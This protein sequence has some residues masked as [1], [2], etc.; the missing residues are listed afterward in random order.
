MHLRC[1]APLHKQL[2][3]VLCHITFIALIK[4]NKKYQYCWL[5]DSSST[6]LCPV[7]PS[8]SALH[9]L[10]LATFATLPPSPTM[11]LAIALVLASCS[12]YNLQFKMVLS[13]LSCHESSVAV[14]WLV[15]FR[16]YNQDFTNEQE[17]EEEEVE[18]D[19]LKQCLGKNALEPSK[20][21]Q[22]CGLSR[23]TT[24]SGQAQKR[25]H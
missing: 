5:T 24:G 10:T 14:Q 2:P 13:S 1:K 6:S 25:Q 9:K 11:T 17:Q 16:N 22:T 4:S 23:P 21:A 19:K 12:W 15:K 3:M 18:G 8:E 7:F 20:Q